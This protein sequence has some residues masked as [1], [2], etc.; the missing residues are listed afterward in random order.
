MFLKICA[1][2]VNEVDDERLNQLPI[3]QIHIWCERERNLEPKENVAVHKLASVSDMPVR[4]YRVIAQA[5]GI[6]G[7]IDMWL[8]YKLFVQKGPI[9][10]VIREIVT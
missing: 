4:W 3:A 1:N 2:V 9:S 10:R 8:I 6:N 5:N 7:I